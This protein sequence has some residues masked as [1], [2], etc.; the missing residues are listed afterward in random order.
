MAYRI[1]GVD[2][3]KKQFLSVS[4]P[5]GQIATVSRDLRL[6]GGSFGLGAGEVNRHNV[7][8]RPSCLTTSIGK[9]FSIWG[10]P[11]PTGIAGL[12][13]WVAIVLPGTLRH[14]DL[15]V[16]TGTVEIVED[17]AAVG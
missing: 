1:A 14:P 6:I 3:H 2:V 17:V 16:G 8:L 13:Q 5:Y 9:P 11:G 12:D 15:P 10:E 7:D 4:R